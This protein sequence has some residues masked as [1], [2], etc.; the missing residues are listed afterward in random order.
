MQVTHTLNVAEEK[1]WC[2]SR[3]QREI[4]HFN[5][6]HFIGN[7]FHLVSFIDLEL[8]IQIAGQKFLITAPCWL[9]AFVFFLHIRFDTLFCFQLPNVEIGCILRSIF[10]DS[11]GLPGNKVSSF[12][13]KL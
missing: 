13:G 10:G 2:M 1:I 6:L 4:C 12:R 3:R 7:R 5:I 11:I 8:L 9:P